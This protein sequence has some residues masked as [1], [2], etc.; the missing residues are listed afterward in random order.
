MARFPLFLVLAFG[1]IVAMIVFALSPL[2]PKPPAMAQAR[3]DQ[4]TLIF[5]GAALA[6][7][8]PA[9]GFPVMPAPGP[10]GD[11]T[12]T[13]MASVSAL[14]PNAQFSKGARLLFNPQ[15]TNAL[16]GKG[17]RVIIVARN[18]AKTPAQATGLGI[19][20]GAPVDWKQV[21]VTPLFAQLVFDIPAS[22]TPVTGLAFW[23][24]VEGQGHGIEVQSIALQ[25][26]TPTSG[27]P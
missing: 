4:G 21:P 18:V 17:F 26:V 2:K 16:S 10:R 1:S 22:K 15:T 13:R 14:Q 25:P 3:M 20:N 23:P 11:Q 12:G 27:T 24:A 5:D 6:E 8:S 7:I 9:K 19:L